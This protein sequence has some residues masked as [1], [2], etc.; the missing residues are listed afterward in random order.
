[1]LDSVQL[2]DSIENQVVDMSLCRNTSFQMSCLNLSMDLAPNLTT[3]LRSMP[4]K[5]SETYMS[6]AAPADRLKLC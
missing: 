2:I 6:Q 4:F 5:E 1:M 3:T